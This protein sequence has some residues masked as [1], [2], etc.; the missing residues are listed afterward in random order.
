MK[1]VIKMTDKE[2]L[3]HDENC[4]QESR[5]TAVEEKVITIFHNQKKL[6]DTLEKLD[7]TQDKLAISIAE[8]NRTFQVLK[9]IGGILVA[10]FGGIVV[11]IITEVI[12]MIH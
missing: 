6:E 3:H 9:V 12:R 1:K 8:L 11:F 5:I 2:F 4:F 10:L 7:K